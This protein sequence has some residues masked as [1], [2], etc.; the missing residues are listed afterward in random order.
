MLLLDL[1]DDRLDS[2]GHAVGIRQAW[3]KAQDESA[4]E[5]LHADAD[6]PYDLAATRHD[7]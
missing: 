5:R 7:L 4:V 1:I 2:R 6:D 3:I